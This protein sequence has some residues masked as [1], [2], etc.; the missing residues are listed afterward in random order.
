[1]LTQSKPDPMPSRCDGV[2]CFQREVICDARGEGHL[3]D[4]TFAE[5]RVTATGVEAKRG[6]SLCL[7]LVF[8]WLLGAS[9]SLKPW[10]PAS[11]PALRMLVF[12]AMSVTDFLGAQQYRGPPVS[13]FPT[14]GTPAGYWLLCQ[15][16]HVPGATSQAGFF[17]LGPSPP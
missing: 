1:M 7:T 13:H 15:P 10:V 12:C 3:H 8:A 5:L 9:F 17:C 16:G 14:T 6:P 4:V 11:S 2:S